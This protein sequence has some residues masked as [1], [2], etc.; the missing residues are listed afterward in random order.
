MLTNNPNALALIFTLCFAALRLA[1]LFFLGQLDDRQLVDGPL[2]RSI[3]C[4]CVLLRLLRSLGV[5]RGP[6]ALQMGRSVLLRVVPRQLEVRGTPQCRDRRSCSTS[7]CTRQNPCRPNAAR[8]CVSKQR[9]CRQDPG[10]PAASGPVGLPTLVVVRK[11]R[12]Q[13]AIKISKTATVTPVQRHITL[14]LERA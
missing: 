2:F 4:S 10:V 6:F 12:V 9:L 14:S 11:N 13:A 8:V 1:R 5:T 3:P 7:S